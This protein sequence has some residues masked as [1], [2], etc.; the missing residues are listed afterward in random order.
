MNILAA[1]RSERH[2]REKRRAARQAL[3]ERARADASRLIASTSTSWNS[4]GSIASALIPSVVS[5]V[6]HGRGK[7][8]AD[9]TL[10]GLLAEIEHGRRLS[11]L[12]ETL[13]AAHP[14]ALTDVR[15]FPAFVESIDRVAG[16]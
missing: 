9:P 3:L 13:D 15:E 16:R 10:A 2:R 6:W 5:V 14:V 7:N 11:F 12:I 1:A 8:V 4:I